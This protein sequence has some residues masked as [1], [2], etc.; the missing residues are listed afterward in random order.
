M[1]SNPNPFRSARVGVV[2]G[3]LSSERDVS[4]NSGAGVLAALQERGYDAVGIDWKQGTALLDLLRAQNVAVVWNALHGTFGEDG[5][6][7][8]LLRCEGIPSTGSGILA[9]ALAMD[10]IMSKRIFDSSGIPTPKWTVLGA[11]QVAAGDDASM[12][13][14]AAALAGWSYPLVVK[15]A[16][17]GSSVGLTIVEKAEQLRDALVLAT[18]H[19][20]PPLI[21]AFLPG[22]ELTVAI[23]GDRALGACEIRPAT[24]L[25]DY[26]AKYLRGDTQYLVPPSVAPDMVAA[27]SEIALRTHRALGCTGYSRV[28]LR[29]DAAGNPFVLE[30]NTLPGMTKTSLIPKIAKAAGMDYPTLCE[31]ILATATV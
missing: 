6:V 3:G 19:Q 11:A 28:D 20:G 5:A 26:E 10:K 12:A 2:M 23:L 27:A 22:A 24:G 29:L 17:E 18:R 9:S 7:Q 14:A 15:P 16:Y 30:V 1:S 4:L 8:G 21:E 25:Y 13:V 31:E